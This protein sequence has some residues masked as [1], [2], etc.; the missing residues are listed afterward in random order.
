MPGLCLPSRVAHSAAENAFQR[1]R[2]RTG[3]GV[4]GGRGGRGRRVV[5]QGHSVR[6]RDGGRRGDE[7]RGEE[8]ED[9]GGAHFDLF[10]GGSEC[11]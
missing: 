11:V 7:R 9:R 2:G 6:T 5:S 10:V 4:R 3:R 8:G 1:I